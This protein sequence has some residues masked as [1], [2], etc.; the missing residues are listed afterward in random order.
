M[1]H[2]GPQEHHQ[3]IV[4]TRYVGPRTDLF[5]KACLV[6]STEDVAFVEA[7]FNDNRT[8]LG[9]TW[10]R[11]PRADFLMFSPKV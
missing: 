10:W 11:A 1:S 7:Q 2:N 5:D 6:R 8:S 9:P 3:G 4:S